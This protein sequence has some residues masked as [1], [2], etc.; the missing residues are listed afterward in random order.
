[1]QVLVVLD[2]S[3][4]QSV[5]LVQ[6]QY[7]V[8][9]GWLFAVPEIFFYEHLRKWDAWRLANLRK[10]KAIESR[11]VLLPGVG[12][13]FRAE[14]RHLKPATQVIRMEK[15]RLVLNERL[16]SRGSFFELDGETKRIS[17]ERTK[18]L[19]N[20]LDTIVEVWRDFNQLAPLKDAKDSEVPD[21]VREMSIDVRDDVDD[22]RGFYRNHR[23]DIYPPAEM[24]NIEWTFFRWH[25]VMLLG[26]LDFYESYG[27]A[28][29]FK[30]EK[31]FNELI[32]LEYLLLA[33][34]VG[35][36][37]SNDKRMVKRFKFLCRDGL[38]L[39]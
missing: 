14:S 9:N 10:L 24:V 26:G 13:M 15:K 16:N 1:M 5:G 35:G 4:L 17:D 30:R 2:K 23:I 31:I 11:V 36:L 22:I 38:V 28:T 33:I 3:F 39:Q 29:P 19:E 27:A 20:R 34:L 8:T 25:Q 18:E 21:R 6:L 12:E 37:A 32:D 7:Y